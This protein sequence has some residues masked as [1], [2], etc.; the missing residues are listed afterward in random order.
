VLVR[1]EEVEFRV[2]QALALRGIFLREELVLAFAADDGL[3]VA[4]EV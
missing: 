3:V 1:G 4:P 2:R